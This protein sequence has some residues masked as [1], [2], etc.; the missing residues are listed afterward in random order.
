MLHVELTAR[1][2]ILLAR[3]FI[4]VRG[5]LTSSMTGGRDARCLVW[6]CLTAFLRT[7]LRRATTAWR[8]TEGEGNEDLRCLAIAAWHSGASIRRDVMNFCRCTLNVPLFVPSPL[9]CKWPDLPQSLLHFQIMLLSQMLDIATSM[10]TLQS[11]CD[12]E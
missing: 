11:S 8:D 4:S 1:I 7:S 3:I 2:Y 6:L 12:R 9:K 5:R 10:N